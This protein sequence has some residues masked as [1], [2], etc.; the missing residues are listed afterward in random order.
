MT[1][2]SP[3][4]QMAGM[5]TQDVAPGWLHLQTVTTNWRGNF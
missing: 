1:N 2:Y 5:P 4:D 3:A